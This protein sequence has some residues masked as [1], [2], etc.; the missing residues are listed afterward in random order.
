VSAGCDNAA[1]IDRAVFMLSEHTN[2][3]SESLY[4]SARMNGVTIKKT[5]LFKLFLDDRYIMFG[6]I[7]PHSLKAYPNILSINT[8]Q[9]CLLSDTSLLVIRALF[10]LPY[11]NTQPLFPNALLTD[12]SF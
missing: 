11:Y 7:D 10:S 2:V 8:T 3:T 5:G 4:I 9:A 12:W 6:S 1:I